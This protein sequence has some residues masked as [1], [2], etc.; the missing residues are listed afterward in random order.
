MFM[1]INL[2]HRK[3]CSF[4]FPKHYFLCFCCFFNQSL[5]LMFVFIQFFMQRGCARPPPPPAVPPGV[6]EIGRF[7]QAL[8]SQKFP[9][10]LLSQKFPNM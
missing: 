4:T 10:R 1:S 8:T 5:D 9:Q 7:P 3:A 2:Q 6:V